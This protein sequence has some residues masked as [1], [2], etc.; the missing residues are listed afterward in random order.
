M[1]VV[2]EKNYL[3]IYGSL[4]LD[5]P[6]TKEQILVQFQRAM[7][8]LFRRGKKTERFFIATALQGLSII[9]LDMYRDRRYLPKMRGGQVL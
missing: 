9:S 5:K 8:N 3:L 4:E 7:C 6:R 2:R 1:T